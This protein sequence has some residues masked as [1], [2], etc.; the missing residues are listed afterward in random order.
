MARPGPDEHTRRDH[1]AMAILRLSEQ[2]LTL[3]EAK[4]YDHTMLT[5]DVVAD[6]AEACKKHQ[7]G[8]VCDEE[9]QVG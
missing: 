2:S 5:V 9:N 8:E 4:Q 6:I 7:I 1:H 3:I